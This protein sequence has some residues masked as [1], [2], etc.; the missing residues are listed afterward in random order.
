MNEARI[1]RI[2][3]IADALHD[4]YA[5]LSSESKKDKAIAWFEGAQWGLDLGGRTCPQCLS[6]ETVP[7]RNKDTPYR[8]TP[9]YRCLPCGQLFSVRTGTEYDDGRPMWEWLLEY[10]FDALQR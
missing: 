5:H 7:Y 3:R 6:S 8:D 2:A 9:P 4:W 1:A 10:E